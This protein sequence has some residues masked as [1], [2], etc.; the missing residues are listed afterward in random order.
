MSAVRGARAEGRAGCWGWPAARGHSG[1]KAQRSGWGKGAPGPLVPP[2]LA[3]RLYLESQDAGCAG[4]HG[5]YTLPDGQVKSGDRDRCQVG[6]GGQSPQGP[7]RLTAQPA[8]GVAP[9]AAHALGTAECCVGLQAHAGRLAVGLAA[10]TDAGAEERARRDEAVALCED[11]VGRGGQRP[12]QRAGRRPRTT[13]PR[14]ETHGLSNSSQRGA[15]GHGEE[16]GVAGGTG[17]WGVG[18]PQSSLLLSLTSQVWAMSWQVGAV[19][20]SGWRQSSVWLLVQ[21]PGEVGQQ[22]HGL[23]LA[24]PPTC[25][26][27]AVAPTHRTGPPCCG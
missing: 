17:G 26:E 14:G 21:V 2:D 23:A 15:G 19:V 13:K 8:G 3:G 4:P 18:A 6:Q 12:G 27:A 20:P 11:P 5:W 1:A 10:I 24:P 16:V 9:A 7:P 22:G 25:A